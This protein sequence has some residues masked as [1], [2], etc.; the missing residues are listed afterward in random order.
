MNRLVECIPNFSEG[1][2]A[3]KVQALA[4]AVRRID[5]VYVLDEEM[6]AD[7][8][9]SVLTFV[10]TPSAAAEAAFQ[11]TKAAAA[12][13]D[14][15]TH[16][17]GH[18]RVGATDVVP[19]VPI[20]GVTME[21]CIELARALGD[22]IGRE[23]DIPVFLYERAATRPE[24][25]NLESIRRGGPAALGERLAGDPAWRPDFGPSTLHPSAGATI[26]GARPPLIAYNVN[27]ETSDERVAKAIA[28]TVRFSSGGLPYVKAIGLALPTKGL[29]QVSMN[30]TNFEE[31][32][33]QT[34][35]EAVRREAERHGVAV[36][37]S[38]V[39]GLIPQGAVLLAV[40]HYL[41]IQHF[42][43]TQVL[44][45]RLELVL[46]EQGGSSGGRTGPIRTTHLRS[47]LVPF[48]DEVAAGSPTP[49]GGSVAALGGALACALGLMACRLGPRKDAEGGT[50]P[51]EG[52]LR[53]KEQ[54]LMALRERFEALIQADADAYEEVL[55]AYR[56][57]K[58]DQERPRLISMSLKK[59]TAVPL[60]TAESAM[61]VTALLLS[62]RALAKPSVSS[63]VKVGMLMALAAADGGLENVKINIK[64]QI[65][66]NFKDEVAERVQRLEGSLVELRGLC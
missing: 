14:L 43:P 2:D 12:M 62:V 36:A 7:H 8:H 65:N 53:A 39:I 30:L 54:R 31:T 44:E 63:D 28:K 55:K 20:R 64:S 56:V 6:D 40:K 24:R 13:I 33:V 16:Q 57:P 10:G 37:D 32:P 60:E 26:V 18:P 5:G 61:E 50:A 1:R 46:A 59:A 48:L 9:R 23:L 27:L 29:V 21:E 4:A 15:R 34:A 41:K 19:F 66:Q 3:G 17:G 51:A 35:Y 42:D 47:S 52:D 38:E 11:A 58:S 49:G 22:R 45:T 25:V